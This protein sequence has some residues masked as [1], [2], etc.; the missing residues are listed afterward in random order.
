MSKL[1]KILLK[2]Y[3]FLEIFVIYRSGTQESLMEEYL[4]WLYYDFKYVVYRT[5]FYLTRPLV[6][7]GNLL[8]GL[9]VALRNDR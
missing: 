1:R 6:V 8:L 3:F 5:G 4:M 2:E 9:L 7:L